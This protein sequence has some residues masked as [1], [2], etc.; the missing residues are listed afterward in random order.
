MKDS[1]QRRE[2]RLD[3][4]NRIDKIFALCVPKTIILKIL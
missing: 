1:P 3:R 2:E 4:I